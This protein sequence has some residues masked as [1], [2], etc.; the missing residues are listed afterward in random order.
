MALEDNFLHSFDKCSVRVMVEMVVTV[1]LS[2]DIDI[3]FY[4]HVLVQQLDYLKVPF[5]CHFWHDTE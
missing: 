1:G 3:I 5:R 4:D 2:V